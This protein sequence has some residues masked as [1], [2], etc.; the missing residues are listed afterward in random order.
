MLLPRFLKWIRYAPTGL[1]HL[2]RRPLAR[3]RPSHFGAD[4]GDLLKYGLLRWPTSATLLPEC[5]SLLVT[6]A[7]RLVLLDLCTGKL[8]AVTEQS[9]FNLVGVAHYGLSKLLLLEAV[10][11]QEGVL[12]WF[13]LE[14]RSL[15]A[16]TGQFRNVWG[17]ATVPDRRIA[18]VAE[19]SSW[20]D[21]KL[22]VVDLKTG[23]VDTLPASL[24]RPRQVLVLDNSNVL[25]TTADGVCEVAID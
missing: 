12:W 11:G 1:L 6:E 16:I 22:K 14:T 23:T 25:V 19:G 7:R 8:D 20:P 13:D 17:L 2:F 9:F 4:D 3:L 18:I 21:G 15:E 10:R 24:H 5:K